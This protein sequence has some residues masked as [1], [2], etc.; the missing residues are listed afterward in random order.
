MQNITNRLIQYCGDIAHNHG[1]IQ[2]SEDEV[3]F[4]IIVEFPTKQ[5]ALTIDI[6]KLDAALSLFGPESLKAY[7]EASALSSHKIERAES[8]WQES[9]RRYLNDARPLEENWTSSLRIHINKSALVDATG[10]SPDQHVI[11]LFFCT[12]NLLGLRKLSMA[13]QLNKLLPDP[14]KK[15]VFVVLDEDVFCDGPFICVTDWENLRRVT[16]LTGTAASAAP[17]TIEMVR[18]QCTWRGLERDYLP[19]FVQTVLAD[20][21]D[22]AILEWFA[23]IRTLLSL[24]SIANAVEVDQNRAELTLWGYAKRSI[25]FNGATAVSADFARDST[26]VY[27]WVYHDVPHRVVALRIVRNVLAQNLGDEPLTNSVLLPTKLRD[28]LASA[29]ANYAVFI[30]DKLENFFELSKEIANYSSAN[31]DYVYKKIADLNEYLLKSMITTLGVVLGA[32]LSA[33]AA[34]NISPLAY[35][36]IFILYALYVAV[37]HVWYLPSAAAME[38]REHLQ[39]FVGR[40]EP[41]KEFLDPKQVQE[42]FRE[43]PRNNEKAFGKTQTLVCLTNA[44]TAA[45]IFCLSGFDIRSL[46]QSFT[47]NAVWAL[48]KGLLILVSW[49]RRV[50]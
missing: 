8:A 12:S 47:F 45:L 18:E 35:S 25:V 20:K 15:S 11:S 48:G 21:P 46:A 7:F 34:I 16:P 41:Y 24:F 32:L 13:D 22:R 33:S 2:V 42:I 10:L 23:R 43:M 49:V 9:L 5:D 39:R 44:V 4:N 6:S 37:F 1:R 3:A 40:M 26:A 28:V 19:E 17:L 29:K 27:D 50:A 14:R 36:S 30:Q 31:V 38:F